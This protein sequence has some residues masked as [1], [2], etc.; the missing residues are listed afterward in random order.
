V[1]GVA[2][3]VPVAAAIAAVVAWTGWVGGG[4]SVALGG[5]VG[6]AVAVGGG[7]L[8]VGVRR[9]IAVLA[10]ARGGAVWVYLL[11][12][13]DFG[14]TRAPL[15]LPGT[16]LAAAVSQE[17]RGDGWS[18]LFWL[19]A[20]VAAWTVAASPTAPHGAVSAEPGSV[21]GGARLH[22]GRIRSMIWLVVAASL[23]VGLAASYV[24][25][26]TQVE[27]GT[28]DPP[29]HLVAGSSGGSGTGS[30]STRPRGREWVL[31]PAPAGYVPG[32]PIGVDGPMNASAF[33]T[34][35]A[36]TGAA[37]SFRFVD[38]YER[39]YDCDTCDDMV[40]VALVEL[41]SAA[42]SAQ[43]IDELTT[44]L[45]G[46]RMSHPR[47]IPSALEVDELHA[48]DGSYEHDIVAAKG[49]DVMIIDGWV[50]SPRLP[51]ALRQLAE[52]QY[53]ALKP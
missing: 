18:V 34:Y 21:M 3:A 41:G 35:M 44:L 45:P 51:T 20:L 26:R 40:D 6:Y 15:L 39:T 12:R 19:L 32:P 29:A 2:A 43:L 23:F 42:E 17:V 46:E 28:A 14:I 37:A 9:L 27:S 5:C 33:N 7:P 48:D 38:G 16:T 50:A 4:L 8:P 36:D 13:Q 11:I 25:A 24:L 30:S 22:A 1:F 49:A 10:T 31:A 53:A 47:S 52:R